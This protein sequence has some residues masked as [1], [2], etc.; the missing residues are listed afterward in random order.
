M[1]RISPSPVRK[2]GAVLITGSTGFV[3]ME[4]LSRY[5][6]RSDRPVHALVRAEDDAG[7]ERRLREV[8]ASLYGRAD[9]YADRV[10]AVPGDLE[11]PGLGLEGGRRQLLA[12]QV[13]EI[14]H[15]AASVSFSLPLEDAREI[16]V[17]GTRRMLKLGQECALGRGGLR[18]FSH[19]STAYVAGDH[20]GEFGEDQLDEGRDSATPTSAPSSRESAWCTTMPTT[21]RSRSSGR[22]SSSESERRAGR[23]RS[24]SSTRR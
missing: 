23:T 2:D 11:S 4:L 20:G 9:A 19:L 13:T 8:L 3:G 18:R 10:A 22:A 12:D 1:T 14:V 6:E 24:T 21:F 15:S 16:N 5:L 17:A 7:A